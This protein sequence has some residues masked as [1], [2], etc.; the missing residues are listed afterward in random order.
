[1]DRVSPPGGPPDVRGTRAI[2]EAVRLCARAAPFAGG[3]SVVL[4]LVGGV[5]P[6]VLAWST[7][8]LLDGLSRHH[9]GQVNLG[10]C[11]LVVLG[12]LTALIS[13]LRRYTDQ[14]MTRRI[15]LRTQI[16]LFTAVSAH[17]GLAE[18]E[19][20]GFH[21]RLRIAREASQFA[22]MQITSSLLTL[23]SSAITLAGFGYTLLRWSPWLAGLVLVSALP[24]L[25]ALAR[26]RS[27]MIIR[28]SP[29]WRRQAFYSAL[30]LDPRAAKE[31]RLFGLAPY[32]RT[33]MTR[34]IR[35]GQAE[36]RVQDRY[37]LRVDLTLAAMTSVVAGVALAY[38]AS[39]IAA[40]HG[41]AGDLVVLIAALG[42]TQT[43][44]TT[45]VMGVASMGELVTMFGHY[46]GITS[47]NRTPPPR[48]PVAQLPALATGIEFHDVWFRYAPEH[49]W[50]LRGV[51]LTI[52]RGSSVALVGSNG[53]GKST[54][55]KLLCGFYPVTRGSITWDGTD[56]RDIDPAALRRRIRATFQD[57]MSYELAAA[58]N[59][60]VGDISG[61]HDQPALAAAAAWAGIDSTLAAL[62]N[63]YDTMLSRTFSDAAGQGGGGQGNGEP[64]VG[65]VLS[66][67]QWQRLALARA[68]LRRSADLLI[69]DE[70][71]SGLDVHAE[72]EIHRRLAEL[73]E[74]RTSL[75]I[76]H[77]LNTVRDADLILVL[78]DGAVIE[79]GDH[80]GLIAADGVYAEMFQLQAAG[81]V[82]PAPAPAGAP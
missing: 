52:P 41:T 19:D 22:P 66:G 51:T 80:A 39:R 10:V 12:V 3:V 33:R 26:R 27:E 17:D 69:L 56:L 77:R 70:P 61:G 30:L 24:T 29:Y 25:Y 28:T 72:H 16:D 71:S 42:S 63:G 65:V 47:V 31:V 32:L 79:R 40:G 68:V 59:I 7:K 14:E 44:L 81:F 50:V 18:I 75:L 34:E 13:H 48:R 82:E 5:T 73:R 11:G 64:T 74:G 76:S 60:A 62:P 35:A 49:D 53:A 8:L 46:L 2:A 15:T 9:T 36:E 37:A 23:A 58:E 6:V 1:V 20:S 55:V 67:G 78:R 43:S 54:V 38:F 57:F 45:V 21:D 4:M